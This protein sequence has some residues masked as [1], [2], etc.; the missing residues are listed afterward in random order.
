MKCR[1]S[2]PSII[3]GQQVEISSVKIHPLVVPL[4]LDCG[5]LEVAVGLEEA[6]A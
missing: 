5:A 6:E 3:T 2:P 4:T 1:L